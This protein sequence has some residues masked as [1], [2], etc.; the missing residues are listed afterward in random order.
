LKSQTKQNKTKQNKTK[1]NKTKQN[2]TKQNKFKKNNSCSG[3]GVRWC[4]NKQKKQLK[5]D[6]F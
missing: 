6:K 3:V 4:E 1:Q 5:S 2:K